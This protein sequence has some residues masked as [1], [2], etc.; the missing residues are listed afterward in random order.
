MIDWTY[1]HFRILMRIIA[2]K[3]LL[4]TEML[5]TNAIQNNPNKLLYFNPV[6]EPI[7]I[8]LGGSDK[9]SLSL[10]AKIAEDAGYSEINLNL[11]CPSPRVQSGSFGACLMTNPQIVA[12]C[13]MSIKNAVS[14]PV[15]AK[16]RIGVDDNDSYEF[17]A[18]FIETLTKAGC[19]KLIIHARI[20]FLNGLSPKQ[21]REIP[22]INYDYV[23]K[24]KKSYPN[25]PIVL[26]GN[27]KTYEEVIQHLKI[28]DG[29]MFGR[30][31]YQEPYT[32]AKIYNSMFKDEQLLSRSEILE[33]YVGYIAKDNHSTL[34]I[35]LTLKPLF[36]LYH[37]QPNAGKWKKKL[38]EIQASRKFSDL[39]K[40][41]DFSSNFNN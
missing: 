33:K 7:A 26:N 8:Q 17:F 32:L 40:L 5:T 15:T 28:I 31:A 13:I 4:Y 41:V 1:S 34:P 3:A 27:I 10:S 24:I 25:T 14:I 19:D 12:D 37:N 38:L 16:T 30:L 22:P 35:T 23:Y 18:D 21:N 36:S 20:A 6:E 9:K 39:E 29:V 11:G 2:P